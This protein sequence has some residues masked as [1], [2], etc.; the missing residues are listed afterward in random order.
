ME[1]EIGVYSNKFVTYP[2]YPS[3]IKNPYCV[4][5]PRIENKIIK[6][7][8]FINETLITQFLYNIY[9]NNIYIG[10]N[11]H[12]DK[13]NGFILWINNFKNINKSNWYVV[14]SKMYKKNILN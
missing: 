11:N 14:I 12:E 13:K 7:Y 1:S 6:E 10:K 4:Y 5:L 9:I 2:I 3:T 8:I